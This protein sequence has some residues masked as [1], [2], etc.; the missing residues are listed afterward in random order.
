MFVEVNSEASQDCSWTHYF[1]NTVLVW[2]TSNPKHDVVYHLHYESVRI[3]LKGLL[4]C[5][6]LYSFFDCLDETFNCQYVLISVGYVEVD[7]HV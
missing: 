4:I 1:V 2:K 7:V 3:C 6:C 5:Y